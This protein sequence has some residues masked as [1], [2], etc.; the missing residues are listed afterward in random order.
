[1]PNG[2]VVTVTLLQ[3]GVTVSDFPADSTA[4]LSRREFTLQSAL[5]LLSTCIIT[6]EGCG[7]GYKSPTNPTPPP[8]TSDITGNISG[9]HGHIATITAAQITTGN[10]ISLNIQGTATHPHTVDVSQDN[11][12][13]LQNRQAVTRDSTNNSGHSH[14][15]TFT[16]A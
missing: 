15:V 3:G 14:T 13:S 6:V 5:A 2:L 9:N 10:A 12:R 16:P 8:A 1:L 4:G 7:S 11:L